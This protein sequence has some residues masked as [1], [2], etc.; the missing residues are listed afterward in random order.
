MHPTRRHVAAGLLGLPLIGS[1]GRSASAESR[2]IRFSYQRSSTLLTLLRSEGV[3]EKRLAPL[4]FEVSWNLF[5]AVIPPMNAGAVDFHADVADAIPIFTQAA[6]A[7]LTFYATEAP[8]PA[9]E[10]I[11]VH[12]DSPITSVAD[13][14]GKK[15]GVS[16]GS[17]CHFI[18]AAALAKAGLAFS[19][20]NP[21]YLEAPDG[22]AA[23]KGRSIDAWVIWDPFLAI[24]QSQYPIRVIAD[25]TGFS[26]YSRY[27]L[28]NNDFVAAHPQ[29][30]AIVF[31]ALAEQGR[32]VKSQ[33]DEAAARLAPMW[34]DIPIDVVKQVNARRSYSVQPVRKDELGD[35]QKIADVFFA[36]GLIPKR[37]DATDVPIWQ[38]AA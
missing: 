8:S 1:L 12:G 26:G 15:V 24:A 5:T 21:A 19:D 27:Y 28:V 14:K 3:L 23:F 35:Q 37:I 38:P 7:K 13:L 4:G 2:K 32:W 11:I 6:G 16:R 31:E 34:G 10:A 17:G 30:V 20:I 22:A 9:A 18:L 33:P 29:A 25:A 36:A